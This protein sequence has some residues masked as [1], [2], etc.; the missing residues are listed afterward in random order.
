VACK[1][2]SQRHLTNGW[3]EQFREV[4]DKIRLSGLSISEYQKQNGTDLNA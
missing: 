1:I 2:A 4:S 3:K